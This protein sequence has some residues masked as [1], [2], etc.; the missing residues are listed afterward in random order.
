MLVDLLFEWFIG[1]PIKK[2]SFTHILKSTAINLGER[3][4]KLS[5]SPIILFKRITSNRMKSVT[6]F[7]TSN[8]SSLQI[9]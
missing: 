6:L 8:F 5:T 9:G 3:G 7:V 2:V 1:K 4:K